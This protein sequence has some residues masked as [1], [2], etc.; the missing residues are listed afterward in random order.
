MK[1]QKKCKF[2]FYKNQQKIKEHNIH[3]KSYDK[4]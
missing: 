2:K 3:E 1:I 4:E